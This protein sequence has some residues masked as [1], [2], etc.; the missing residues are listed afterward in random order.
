MIMSKKKKIVE[1][2]I[3]WEL[4]DPKGRI[5]KRGKMPVKSFVKA[6]INFLYAQFAY[7]STIST[8]DI[9]GTSRSVN[10]SY[11]LQL[12]AGAGVTA[13]GIVVGS[14]DTSVTRDDYKLGSQIAHGSGTGQLMYGAVSIDTPVA[15]S[16]G[17]LVRVMRVFTNNSGADVTVK[18]IGLYVYAVS[19]QYFCI[20]RDVLTT[21]VTIPN[22]YSWTV[23]YNF[24]FVV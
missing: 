23:R 14:S 20:V 19:G 17:Y 8:L 1:A 3:E 9:G 13:F 24:Y 10:Y 2:Y 21:P 22:G 4:L 5:V 12:N 16:T 7:G 15:Y 11:S 18:E 6:W